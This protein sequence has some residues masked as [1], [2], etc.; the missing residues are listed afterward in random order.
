MLKENITYA[1]VAN[2]WNIH[3]S[4]RL[5]LYVIRVEFLEI[6]EFLAQYTLYLSIPRVIVLFQLF[7]TVSRR[8]ISGVCPWELKICWRWMVSGVVLAGCRWFIP[9]WMWWWR[10]V[11]SIVVPKLCFSPS[12]DQ[13][14][15]S[16]RCRSVGEN[17]CTQNISGCRN[18]YMSSFLS[19]IA[20]CLSRQ[21]CML[22]VMALFVIDRCGLKLGPCE[23]SA[24]QVSYICGHDSEYLAVG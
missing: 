24:F 23:Y 21:G 17:S 13:A 19:F 11:V 10:H 5:F 16:V 3:N 6:L 15:P 4:I 7:L 2:I 1:L 14:W 8:R 9:D 18:K 20:S 22:I 12:V